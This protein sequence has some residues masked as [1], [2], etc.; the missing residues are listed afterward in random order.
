MKWDL[1]YFF[2]FFAGVIQE[3][4]FYVGDKYKVAANASSTILNICVRLAEEDK[5]LRT[6]RRKLGFTQ[7]VQKDL[8]PIL[9]ECHGADT[10]STFAANIK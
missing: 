9:V 10:F 8:A 7:I 1:K 3:L 6:F 5:S 4:G 2:F